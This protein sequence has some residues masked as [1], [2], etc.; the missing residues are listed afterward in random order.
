MQGP[1]TRASLISRLNE[2]ASE[3]VWT[4]FVS[5]YR[6]LIIRVAI[7]KGLQ[8]AD[9]EDLAQDV[10]GTVRRSL[11]TFESQGLG[12]FRGW[13]FQ[14]TRNLV[15][16]HLTRSK[17]PIGSGDSN[18]QDLLLQQPER[19]DETAGLFDL[20]LRRHQ[21]DTAAREVQPSV[22]PATWQAFWMTA[23]EG[24]PISEVALQL[25]KS[26]GAIR[27][28]KCRVLA[29]LQKQTENYSLDWETKS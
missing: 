10:L 24:K 29:R 25:G 21:L 12:S 27:M 14:I 11:S 4:E 23:V 6:P 28:A 1:E 17:G 16:N 20:E 8:H 2:P 13:L 18:I 19:T 15:V 5:I 3:E 7:A 22:E 26:E 9:A